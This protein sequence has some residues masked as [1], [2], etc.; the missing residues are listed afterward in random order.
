MPDSIENISF[1]SEKEKE[2]FARKEYTTAPVC[3]Y[4]ALEYKTGSK[5]NINLRFQIHA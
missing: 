3:W 4:S 2:A 5:W 1:D